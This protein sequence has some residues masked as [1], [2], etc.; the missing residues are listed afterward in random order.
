MIADVNPRQYGMV[1]SY[2]IDYDKL[3]W[4]RKGLWT[5]YPDDHIARLEGTAEAFVGV[6]LSGIAGPASPPEY[7]WRHDT[8]GLGTNDFRSTKENII[9]AYLSSSKARGP[10]VESDGNQHVRCWMEGDVTRMLIAEYNNPG[11]ERFFRGHASREDRA[12]QTGQKIRGFITFRL[13]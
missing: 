11:S 7:S 4:K 5:T 6:E 13:N 10:V 9:E 12:L 1:L 2:P 8:N 3:D